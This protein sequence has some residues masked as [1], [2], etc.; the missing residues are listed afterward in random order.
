[1]P[2][3]WFFL[4]IIWPDSI[5]A[6]EI[7]GGLGTAPLRPAAPGWSET[8]MA[9]HAIAPTNPGVRVPRTRLTDDHGPEGEASAW[10]TIRGMLEFSAEP[11]AAHLISISCVNSG[12][13]TMKNCLIC[14]RNG[15]PKHHG[16][17]RDA[18]RFQGCKWAFP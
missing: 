14:G 6:P 18:T 7:G 3:T 4:T 10:V 16:K 17:L 8:V 12:N 1:M 13:S 11:D 5:R 2:R 9:L 15:I